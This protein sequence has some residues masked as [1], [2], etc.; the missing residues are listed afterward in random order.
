MNRPV[1]VQNEEGLDAKSKFRVRET[2]KSESLDANF[3]LCVQDRG[4]LDANVSFRVQARLSLIKISLYLFT[5]SSCNILYIF[6]TE[7]L[8]LF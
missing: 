3:H 1:G 6:F 7:K 4:V 2:L 8:D 5:F